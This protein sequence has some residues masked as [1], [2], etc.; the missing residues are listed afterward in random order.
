MVSD[1]QPG[2]APA[3]PR[4]SR[5]SAWT[6]LRGRLELSSASAS[7]GLT[8]VLLVGVLA[9]EL[10]MIGSYVGALH[11]PKPR[12]VPI[13]IVGPPEVAG[14]IADRLARAGD[15]LDPR[16]LPAP[17]AARRAIDDREVYAALIPG[18][19]SDRLVVAEAASAPVAELLPAALERVEPPGRRLVV[20]RVKRLPSDDPR[21]LSPFYLIV[22]WLLGGYVGA[23]V[24]GLARGGGAR[25]LRL[26][27]LRLAVLGAYALASGVL[28]T[29]LVQELVG[30]LEG[31]TLALMGAG[32]LMV[33]ATG[34]ATAALQ[35]LLGIAGTALAIVVFVAIGNPA[36]GG[37]LASELL[38]PALW[39]DIGAFL[40]P[41]AG[42]SL[43]RNIAYFDGNAVGGPLLVLGAY[44]LVG[45]LIAIGVRG[46]SVPASREEAEATAGLAAAA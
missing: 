46:R 18:R 34:A 19:R 38:M 27:G 11:E 41:G 1:E 28:G 6:R 2:R 32:A 13:A 17:A 37:P 24:L 36:S 26:A 40:P 20:E 43:V 39:R 15:A 33:F 14:P 25:T 8:A 29:V 30:V 23:T 45:S 35:S 12:D 16:V 7:F 44:A 3:S 9:V 5:A 21:G 22:G 10:V 42:T 31:S 4:R